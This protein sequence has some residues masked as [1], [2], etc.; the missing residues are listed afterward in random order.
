MSTVKNRQEGMLGCEHVTHSWNAQTE[1]YVSEWM[2][3]VQ[4]PVQPYSPT[5]P[6]SSLS[7]SMYCCLMNRGHVQLSALLFPLPST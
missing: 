5:P 4:V 7:S 3:S 1:E 2:R 6:L